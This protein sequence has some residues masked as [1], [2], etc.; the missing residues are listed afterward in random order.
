MAQSEI[1][2]NIENI[3]PLHL[4]GENNIKF[5]LL[6]KAYPELTFT[7]RGSQIKIIGDKKD[8][9]EAKSKV[10]WMVRILK[11]KNELTVHA[12]EDLLA[13][14]DRHPDYRYKQQFHT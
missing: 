1:V 6:K 11:E 7:N 13:G 5:N 3:D 2:L 10:E 9:Q 12:V 8:S 14:L 4:Y